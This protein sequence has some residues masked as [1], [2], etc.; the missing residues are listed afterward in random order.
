MD[1]KNF[2][3][4]KV[5]ADEECRAY[6]GPATMSEIES[7]LNE[8]KF[9]IYII[10]AIQFSYKT[11]EGKAGLKVNAGTQIDRDK[12]TTYKEHLSGL[13][14]LLV[15]VGVVADI[16][17]LVL[18]STRTL[19]TKQKASKDKT[20]TEV[21]TLHNNTFKVYKLC[22][23]ICKDLYGVAPKGGNGPLDAELAKK[24]LSF[25]QALGALYEVVLRVAKSIL[26]EGDQLI[27]GLYEIEHPDQEETK[28]SL[29]LALDSMLVGYHFDK[30][31]GGLGTDGLARIYLAALLE[32]A[33]LWGK[34]QNQGHEERSAHLIDLLEDH[35]WRSPVGL[36][37]LILN[38]TRARN[39]TKH[40]IFQASHS[41]P[42][43]SAKSSTFTLTQVTYHQSPRPEGKNFADEY[44]AATL[45]AG[46]GSL[47]A[48]VGETST[49]IRVLNKADV[50]SAI[51]LGLVEEISERT[52]GGE[53]ASTVL[54]DMVSRMSSA[55]GKYECLEDIKNSLP[56]FSKI[57]GSA[58]NAFKI[59][60]M[61][62]GAVVGF[63]H[64]G[65]PSS[66]AEEL[67]L[68]C[69]YVSLGVPKGD[70]SSS[71]LLYLAPVAAGGKEPRQKILTLASAGSRS[72]VH[73]EKKAVIG[74]LDPKT[75]AEIVRGIR[76]K[77]KR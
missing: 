33:G 3:P 11:G 29:Q 75:Y 69:V 39:W 72:T 20:K 30:I 73:Q 62:K 40:F 8:N 42:V 23:G 74:F 24:I 60:P 19:A 51:I 1:L 70:A 35:G 15:P 71:Y 17:E 50:D 14:I 16:N 47:N 56:S 9:N 66:F 27:T 34:H 13:T 22:V 45:F 31:H 53:Q 44:P 43:T 2:I 48:I 77:I 57:I 61:L 64:E 26:T 76:S 41:T 49:E 58:V 21:V 7:L 36:K 25:G 63:E 4:L 46:F 59:E 65:M 28:K 12:F 18:E 68:N 32:N 6:A 55:F 38:H 54:E 10:R 37:D 5:G 67:G 52:A